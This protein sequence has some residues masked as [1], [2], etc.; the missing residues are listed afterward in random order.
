MKYLQDELASLE[1]DNL[2]RRL[3][4]VQSP[5]ESRLVI[6]NKSLIN[7]CSNDYLGLCNDSRVKDA[8]IG[9]IEEYGIGSGASRLISG[10]MLLH[11]RLEE[12]I[13]AF[14]QA[15]ASLVFNSGYCANLGIISSLMSG[16]S[17]V[18]S[19]RLN[20]ASIVDAIILSRAEFRRYPHRD[21]K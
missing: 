15:E 10:N 7:L 12:R 16:N 5:Q 17:I 21:V 9:A 3:R 6:N 14:K 4:L 2:L 13:N 1:Q 11:E 8:A 18:F 19:D 20:H